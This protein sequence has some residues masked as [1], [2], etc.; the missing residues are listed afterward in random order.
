MHIGSHQGT[1]GII[2]LQKRDQSSCDGDDLRWCDIHKLH[3]LRS[4]QGE[5]VAKTARYQFICQFAFI[6][7]PRIGLGD[8]VLTLFDSRQVN[9]LIGDFAI[10]HLTVRSLKEAILICPGKNCQ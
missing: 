7:D 6:V 2:M 4:R 1:V 10:D 9:R 5:F 3:V 8:D